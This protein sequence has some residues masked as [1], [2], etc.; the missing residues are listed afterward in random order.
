[1]S[2]GQVFILCMDVILL[3]ILFCFYNPMRFDLDSF[4]LLIFMSSSFSN[5]IALELP[6]CYFCERFKI[7]VIYF[8]RSPNSILL[9]YFY[10]NLL[11]LLVSI[12]PVL[13]NLDSIPRSSDKAQCG[14]L[15]WKGA[16]ARRGLKRPG[17]L[18]LL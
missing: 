17:V 9:S 8:M 16:L 13:P 5:F 1:M 11:F 14:V 15:S 6:I 12:V 3:I 18:Q 7:K 10:S 2:F 4:Y